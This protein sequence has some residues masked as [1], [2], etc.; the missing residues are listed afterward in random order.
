MPSALTQGLCSF[1]S[2]TGDCWRW[3]DSSVD[4]HV[5]VPVVQGLSVDSALKRGQLTAESAVRKFMNECTDPGPLY[6]LYG[7]RVYVRQARIL[8]VRHNTY[9]TLSSCTYCTA[10]QA[11]KRRSTLI[12]HVPRAC[13]WWA[14]LSLAQQ[15]AVW[16]QRA[17]MPNNRKRKK[18]HGKAAREARDLERSLR[19][20]DGR[21]AKTGEA[22]VVSERQRARARDRVIM[23]LGRRFEVEGSEWWASADVETLRLSTIVAYM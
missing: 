3:R 4:L 23:V 16:V 10:F 9:I 14:L 7:V 21:D 8:Y 22:V 18:T 15:P 5:P 1:S 11:V 6:R 2:L 19:R 17:S 12:C 20:A 13:E